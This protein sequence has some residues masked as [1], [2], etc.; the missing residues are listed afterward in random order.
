MKRFFPFAILFILVA[1]VGPLL[2]FKKKQPDP[3]LFAYYTGEGG[4]GLHL[5]WSAD[6][7]KWQPLK[8]GKSFMKPG[9]GDYVMRDPHLSQTPDGMYHL[10]WA[11]GEHRRD[12]GY[13]YSKNLFEWSA[14]RLIPVMESDTLVMNVWSPEMVYDSDNQRFMLYWSSTV[15]KKFRETDKQN[16]SL[17][18]GLRYN[19]RLYRKFSS[20]LRTWGNTELFFEP[21]FNV[22]DG[23]IVED[24]GRFMMFFKDGTNLG[25]NIQNNIKVS[26]SYSLTGPY[27]TK[28]SVVSRR[29][30]AQSPMAIRIDSQFVVYFE[31][32]KQR[33][34][35]G[36]ITKNFKDWKDITDSLSF[37][38]GA[39]HGTVIRV[40]V[41]TLEKLK[42]Q[43]E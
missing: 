22:T 7:F 27:D 28:V 36:V 6:G 24:S 10:V 26:K 43:N 25:K 40:P 19:H 11:T 2:P 15:P 34:M 33:K 4:S 9:I 1:S 38:K 13:A 37:P 30:W 12:I 20:D 42:D 31:K 16:D 18:S 32:Y 5:A 35:G 41:K 3:Y 17:P 21:G 23:H 8:G 14:Q 29:T 39:K